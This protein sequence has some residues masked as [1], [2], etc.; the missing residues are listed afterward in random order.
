MKPL[1]VVTSNEQCTECK[2]PLQ[3]G[4]VAIVHAT[5]TMCIKCI[6]KA[7]L[8]YDNLHINH[9][10]IVLKNHKKETDEVKKGDISQ[11]SFKFALY[12]SGVMNCVYV[13]QDKKELDTFL[14]EDFEK[15]K[16]EYENKLQYEIEK[17]PG[18]KVGDWCICEGDKCRI[19][20]FVKFGE[21]RW[22][23]YLSNGER[24]NVSKLRT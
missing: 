14:K 8:L 5:G 2:K 24:E 16:I 9:I 11:L 18:F 13:F 1:I 15:F 4:D 20:E 10:N 6:D 23:A 7:K 3:F 21:H 17:L 22:G 19:V 12:I